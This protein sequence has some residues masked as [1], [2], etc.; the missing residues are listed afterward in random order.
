MRHHP[1]T[2]K[3]TPFM[4]MRKTPPGERSLL[5][6]KSAK[7][8]SLSHL[9]LRNR[10]LKTQYR[11]NRYRLLSKGLHPRRHLL[12]LDGQQEKREYPLNLGTFMVNATL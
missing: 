1:I 8:K 3:K 5:G 9:K 7:G 10:Q 4:W 2:T 6:K 11:R 12:D